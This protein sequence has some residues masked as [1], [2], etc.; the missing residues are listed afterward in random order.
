M[1]RK[2]RNFERINSIGETNRNFDSCNS[3][4]P[5]IYMNCMS[6]NFRLFHVSNFS[7]RIFRIFLLMYTGSRCCFQTCAAART[8]TTLPEKVG[9]D[10][11][12]FRSGNYRPTGK[13]DIKPQRNCI[14]GSRDVTS[15]D[16]TMVLNHLAPVVTRRKTLNFGSRYHGIG[17]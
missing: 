11:T 9:F 2:I 14:L 17:M 6:Q 13:W 16:V 10:S 15:C 8:P 4:E 7:V 5:A 1:S 3:W 12:S